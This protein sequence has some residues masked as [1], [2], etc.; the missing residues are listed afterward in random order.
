MKNNF[1]KINLLVVLVIVLVQ[2]IIAGGIFF[3]FK[4]ASGSLPQQ[5]RPMQALPSTES[6]S[7]RR[8]QEDTRHEPRSFSDSGFSGAKDYTRD[9][10][11]FSVGDIIVNPAGTSTAFFITTVLVEYRQSDK[12]LPPELTNK[13][14]LF[15]DRMT[16]Y[17]SRLTV[18]ELRD[19]ENRD[20]FRDDIMRIINNL[21][22]E[23]RITD[24]FF[25]QF[26]IQQ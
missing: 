19:M 23:G 4:Y 12:R 1:G 18:E 15:R 5:Q 21:L 6:Q 16:G 9:F 14:P 25:E 8:P 20:I 24:V 17:F 2:L 13:A 10:A 22:V 26:L 11:M 3:Y 7:S